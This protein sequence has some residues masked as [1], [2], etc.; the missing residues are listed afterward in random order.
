M[1][2]YSKIGLSSSL[3]AINSLENQERNF[4]DSYSFNATGDRNMISG[5]N[6]G[7]ISADVITGGTI[8]AN[9][10]TI[11][12]ANGS[13]IIDSQG[14]NSPVAFNRYTFSSIDEVVSAG[15][16]TPAAI[17][18]SVTINPTKSNFAIFAFNEYGSVSS[19]ATA[20]VVVQEILGTFSPSNIIQSEFTENY[21]KHQSFI[22]PTTIL[23]NPPITYR[24]MARISGGSGTITYSSDFYILLLGSL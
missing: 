6:M 12:D 3:S 24:V 2:D 18:G 16:Y 15:T 7:T 22:F 9:L 13:A 21:N 4:N 14:F 8:N 17:D 19:G 10:I 1:K 5:Y 11:N 23:F 20:S